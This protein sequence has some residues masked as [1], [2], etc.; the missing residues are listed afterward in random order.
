V[1][2]VNRRNAVLGWVVWTAARRALQ[3]SGK[4]KGAKSE[5]AES[6]AESD[7][8]GRKRRLGA[9]A[10]A[11]LAAVG[12]GVATYMRTRGDDEAGEPRQ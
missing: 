3:R 12:V 4:P 5:A 1:S 2:I 9:G 6:R 8:P 11:F 10:I 7:S